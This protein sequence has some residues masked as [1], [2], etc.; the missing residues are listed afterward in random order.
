MIWPLF[1]I[2]LKRDVC[3]KMFDLESPPIL[4]RAGPSPTSFVCVNPLEIP[5]VHT[6]NYVFEVRLS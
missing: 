2:P 6:Q 3:A 1:Y 5:I 4:I